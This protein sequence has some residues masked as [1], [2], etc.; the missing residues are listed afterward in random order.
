MRWVDRIQETLA[1]DRNPSWSSPSEPD[2]DQP[3]L[4][5]I[6]QDYEHPESYG[7][8]DSVTTSAM[9]ETPDQISQRY[10]QPSSRAP[11]RNLT[12]IGP[13]DTAES[14]RPPSS[15]AMTAWSSNERADIDRPEQ[16]SSDPKEPATHKMPDNAA[17]PSTA[18]NKEDRTVLPSQLESSPAAVL[19]AQQSTSANKQSP[20]SASGV[21]NIELQNVARNQQAQRS[22]NSRTKQ[23]GKEEHGGGCRC[24]IM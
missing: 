18:P 13:L 19:G 1:D 7:T 8:Q 3:V 14:N 2:I 10:P 6:L 15:T 9:S 22:P 16:R 23:K 12:S 21:H 20:T 24:V 11:N 5:G 17:T 4:A